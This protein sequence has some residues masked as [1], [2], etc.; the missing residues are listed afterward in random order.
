MQN[1]PNPFN[2]S[3]SIQYSIKERSSVELVMYD[4]LG[5]EVEVLVKEQQDAGYYKVHFNAGSL[6][7]EVYFYRLKAGNFVETKKMLL[8][9]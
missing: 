6:S 8:L 5:R 9:K 7:S 4:V 3:T 2:P 1:Y